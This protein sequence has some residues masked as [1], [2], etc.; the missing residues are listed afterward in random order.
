MLLS[1][2]MPS[3]CEKAREETEANGQTILQ[4]G[5]SEQLKLGHQSIG[6]GTCV[7]IDVPRLAK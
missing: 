2:D 7:A 3:Q 1:A 4:K 6:L 5:Q